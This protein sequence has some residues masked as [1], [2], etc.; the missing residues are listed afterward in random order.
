MTTFL[1]G[2]IST[3][4]FI[5]VAAAVSILFGL[6]NAL[7]VM[8]VHIITPEEEEMQLREDKHII[9]LHEMVRI[10]KLIEEGAH[11]FLWQEYVVVSIFVFL[12][13]IVIALTVEETL[14]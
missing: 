9:K 10:A 3:E 13:A 1:T 11:T 12:F 7:M 4:Y 6:F 5:L 8:R 14:G 2:S